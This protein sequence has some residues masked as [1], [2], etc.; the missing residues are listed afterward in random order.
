MRVFIRYLLLLTIC[1]GGF[2]SLSAQKLN[3]TVKVNSSAIQGTNRELFISLEEALHTFINGRRW[4]DD[5]SGVNEKI[6]CSFTLVITEAPSA[7]S[8][9]GEL[10]VQSRRPVRDATFATPMLNMRDREVDFDYMEYQPLSFD[11]GYIRGNLT[12][13]IA[14]YVYLILGMDQDS[15]YASGGTACFRQMELIAANVQP[16]GWSGWDRYGSDRGRAAIAAA[17]ND[18]SLEPYRRMW[19][20]YHAAG[21]DQLNRSADRG[22][23][24]MAS[25]VAVI[26]SLYAERPTS[27][28]IMLFGDAKLDEL[29]N[30]LSRGNREQKR[31][32]F[33][34]LKRVY[35]SRTAALEKLR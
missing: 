16:Y 31:K 32:A 23:D 27:V 34:S 29:V 15:R 13:I 22:L 7:Y 21:L 5:N 33:E 17:F 10:Y 3:A 35:P 26:S 9:R 18:G 2:C 11:P 28:L 19:Y 4:S 1:T 25:S 8:F 6:D 14:Y 12:A 20:D 30:L 24:A